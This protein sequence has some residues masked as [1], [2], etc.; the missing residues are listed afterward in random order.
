MYVYWQ[1]ADLIFNGVMVVPQLPGNEVLTSAVTA[2]KT[3][4]VT[5]KT[6]VTQNAITQI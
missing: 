2:G 3:D 5:V 4:R 6:K 1:Y